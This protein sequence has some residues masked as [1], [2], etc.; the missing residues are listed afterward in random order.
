MS[1]TTKLPDGDD[2]VLKLGTEMREIPREPGKV[3]DFPDLP[4]I[5]HPDIF[6]DVLEYFGKQYPDVIGTVPQ[7]PRFDKMKAAY[8]GLNTGLVRMNDS[9]QKGDFVE[10]TV[11]LTSLISLTMGLAIVLGIDIRPLWVAAHKARMEDKEV[12]IA[13]LLDL[14]DPL[15][16][17]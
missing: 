2:E 14:Q 5:K 17:L 4:T 15:E 10:T 1:N 8:E 13:L 6:Q 16:T 9:I 7:W 11:N 12:N 3:I